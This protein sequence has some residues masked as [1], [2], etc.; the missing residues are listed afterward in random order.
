MD[1][2]ASIVFRYGADAHGEPERHR[3]GDRR[4]APHTYT[5]TA[6]VVD[7]FGPPIAGGAVSNGTPTAG[8]GS[9]APRSTAS[10]VSAPAATAS[11][12]W[13]FTYVPGSI[14][15]PSDTLTV[16]N[17]PALTTNPF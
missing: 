1:H 8:I 7:Q 12:Q 13:T 15:G 11:G 16:D 10:L 17:T 5:V 6:Q 14:A 9:S 4:Y 2:P 3:D